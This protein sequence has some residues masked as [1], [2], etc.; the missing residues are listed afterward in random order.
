MRAA[1]FYI[2]VQLAAYG[3]DIGTFVLLVD[4][5][6]IGPLWANI[7]AKA[8]AGGF[9]FFSHRHVTFQSA[10]SESVS[11]QGLRYSILL[12]ANSMA[13]SAMLALFMRVMPSPALAKVVA[14]IILIA[15]SFRLSKAVVFRGARPGQGN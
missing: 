8:V 10:A 2:A 15:A 3:L 14:D 4:V 13:S 9:A 6:A 1:A 5:F 12:I 7:C 11:G